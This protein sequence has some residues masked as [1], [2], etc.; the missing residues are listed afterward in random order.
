[1]SAGEIGYEPESIETLTKPKS[2]VSESN[3]LQRRVDLYI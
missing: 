3:G 1:M 2:S